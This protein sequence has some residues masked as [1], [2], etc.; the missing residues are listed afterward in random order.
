[1]NPDSAERY[2]LRDGLKG[3]QAHLP[4]RRMLLV[5]SLA[6]ISVG[7]LLI[8]TSLADSFG[9]YY[10]AVCLAAC[11]LGVIF[12]LP[13]FVRNLN[14]SLTLFFFALSLVPGVIVAWPVGTYGS[15]KVQALLIALLALAVPAVLPDLRRSLS[16]LFAILSSL[17][18]AAC[19]LLLAFGRA[20][21]VGRASVF[22]LN[23]IG[24]ARAT[25]LFAVVAVV[26]IVLPWKRRQG[27]KW[28]LAIVA[29]GSLFCTGLTGSRGPILSAMIAV[30]GVVVV[31]MMRRKVRAWIVVVLVGAIVL[32]FVALSSSG[33]AGLERLTSDSD[34]GRSSLINDSIA[35][36]LAHPLGVGWGNLG[37]YIAFGAADGAR[38]YPHN[39][40]VE[41]LVEGGVFAIAG[42]VALV[43][44][45][46]K[47]VALRMLES[48]GFVEPILLALTLYALANAQVSSD[49]VGNR[50]LWVFL[51]LSICLR[52]VKGPRAPL[53]GPYRSG[54]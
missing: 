14:H 49:I 15:E 8:P 35:V 16:A 19:F 21:D 22:D 43:L 38:V 10:L 30:A 46:L 31:L 54:R 44:V 13:F 3:P 36:F 17:S 41:L 24:L 51:G 33:I 32:A 50:M 4:R 48:E 47:N 40:L 12:G 28:I 29:V 27:Q 11:G 7:N 2:P 20:S 42:F 53:E 39:I 6:L 45:A 23:P 1:M 37:T 5:F 9:A 18:L 25:G 52:A 26:L 34:S